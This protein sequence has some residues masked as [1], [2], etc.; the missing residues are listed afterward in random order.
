MDNDDV[1]SLEK[2]GPGRPSRSKNKL[3][4]KRLPAGQITMKDILTNPSVLS[5]ICNKVNKNIENNGSKQEY[6]EVGNIF[7]MILNS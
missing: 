4:C 5:Q 3:K 6:E 1:S 2:R 7:S